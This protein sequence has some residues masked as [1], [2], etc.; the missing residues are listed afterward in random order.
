MPRNV[1]ANGKAGL[2]LIEM[3]AVMVIIALLAGLAIAAMPGTG[4]SGLKALAMQAAALCRRERLAA[5]LARADRHVYLDQNARVL[6]GDD[7]NDPVR[8]PRDVTLDILAG[9]AASPDDPGVV[10]FHPDGA[11]SGAVLNL[12]GKGQPMK[13]VSIG[14]PVVL[15]WRRNDAWCS[16]AGFTLIEALVAL[17]LLAAFAASLEPLLYHAHHIFVGP[18]RSAC[19]SAIALSLSHAVQPR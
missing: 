2:T 4:R 5:I 17:A 7:A 3:M 19:G 8:V 1:R 6:F 16:K 10:T 11:A 14:T 15:P 12:P 9:D 18:R 13:S